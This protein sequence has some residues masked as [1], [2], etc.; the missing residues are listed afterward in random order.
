MFRL[1]FVVTGNQ[2][3]LQIF[4]LSKNNDTLFLQLLLI[5][6]IRIQILITIANIQLCFCYDGLSFDKAFS[7]FLSPP[8][9]SPLYPCPLYPFC[10]LCNFSS[11]VLPHSPFSL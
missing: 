7:I 1:K 10:M 6:L 2:N 5:H 3:L 11:L 9:N 4:L 8:M